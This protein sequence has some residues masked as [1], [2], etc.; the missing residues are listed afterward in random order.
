M[1]ATTTSIDIGWEV[2]VAIIFVVLALLVIAI[3]ILSRYPLHHY[4]RVGFFVERGDDLSNPAGQDLE[5][6]WP[7]PDQPDDDTKEIPP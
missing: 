3:I 2:L 5:E 7:E 1:T 4:L 6:R